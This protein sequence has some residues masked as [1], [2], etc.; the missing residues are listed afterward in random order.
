MGGQYGGYAA[1]G[2]AHGINQ[3]VRAL[4]QGLQQARLQKLQQMAQTQH[5]AN[6]DAQMNLERQKVALM[7]R[8]QILALQ[9]K[10]TQ[11]AAQNQLAD[12]KINAQKDIATQKIKAAKD[13]KNQPPAVMVPGAAGGLSKDAI[14]N[15]GTMFMLTGQM[16]SMGM[17][18]SGQPIR[19]AIMN[20]AAEIGKKN[21][22]TP[23]QLPLVR[24][25]YAAMANSYKNLQKVSNVAGV[26]ID[27]FNGTAKQALKSS[28]KVF[29]TGSP[30]VNVGLN[31][32]R[33]D[34]QGDPT[35][36]Q[37]DNYNNTLANEYARLMGSF[38]GGSGATTEGA[39]KTALDKLSSA[40]TPDQYKAAVTGL[41][42]EIAIRKD[43]FS[44][45]LGSLR[46]GLMKVQKGDFK[47][48]LHHAMSQQPPQT[49]MN[50]PVEPPPAQSA[51]QPLGKAPAGLADGPHTYDGK[52]VVVRGGVVYAQ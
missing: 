13:L 43:A 16:P 7:G 46:D 14:Q 8:G 5:Q 18:A 2:A 17:G 40:H 22:L 32:V 28:G 33:K 39:R 4:A 31:W 26:S 48:L 15:A 23:E 6:I 34:V 1:G 27:T 49:A 10:T 19:M 30:L 9:G 11:A 38:S 35:L 50:P 25:A 12:K 29:R 24:T 52:P 44:A 21:G 41:Q 20:G 42:K 51:G 47:P 37:F 3:G 45:H 36:T